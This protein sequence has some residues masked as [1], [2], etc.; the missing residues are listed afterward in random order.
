MIKVSWTLC[1]AHTTRPDKHGRVVLVPCEKC[2]LV[3]WR[4]LVKSLFTRFQKNTDNGHVT[5][6]SGWVVLEQH[7][8]VYLAKLDFREE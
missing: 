1:T 5:C 8:Y 2:I 3:Q 4:T 6:L 7:V